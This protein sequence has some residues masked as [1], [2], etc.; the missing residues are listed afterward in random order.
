MSIDE[1]KNL[2][3]KFI[4]NFQDS[5][6]FAKIKA[7]GQDL[8]STLDKIPGGLSGVASSLLGKLG[9]SGA[10]NGMVE[11]LLS[12]LGGLAKTDG[13]KADFSKLQEAVKKFIG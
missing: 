8:I 2:V 4:S 1:I 5:E 10:S 7:N 9:G 6:D 11:K 3:E 13:A 12:G